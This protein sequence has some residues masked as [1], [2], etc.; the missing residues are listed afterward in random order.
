MKIREWATTQS[1][2]FIVS[3]VIDAGEILEHYGEVLGQNFNV[4][5]AI[6]RAAEM[7]CVFFDEEENWEDRIKKIK[8]I[9]Y[10]DWT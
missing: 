7:L 10:S 4:G 9:G 3:E 2:H 6:D 8:E 1:E 5:N